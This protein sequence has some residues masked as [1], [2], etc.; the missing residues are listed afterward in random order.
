MPPRKRATPPAD[1]DGK[2][3]ANKPGDL[4]ALRNEVRAEP[5]GERDGTLA[6]PLGDT[7][8]RVKDFMDWP[9]SANEDI[10]FGRITRWAAKVLDGRD[11]ERIW[12]PMDPTN[13]QAI[14]FMVSWEKLSGLPLGTFLTSLTS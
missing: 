4:D 5:D 1:L 8:V 6:V 10:A 9:S 13:R 7:I 3:A 2:Q 12:A 14:E 11:Y